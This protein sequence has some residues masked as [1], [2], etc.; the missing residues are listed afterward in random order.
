MENGWTGTRE[1]LCWRI[2]Q[3][4]AKKSSFVKIGQTQHNRKFT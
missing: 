3:N 1:I 4:S 2:A